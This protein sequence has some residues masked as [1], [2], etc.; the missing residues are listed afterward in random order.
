MFSQLPVRHSVHRGWVSLVPCP[1][2]EGV[3]LVQGPFQG[4]AMSRR[5]VVT[6]PPLQTWDTTGYDW[7]ARGIHP[8]GMLSCYR[9]IFVITRGNILTKK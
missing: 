2:W 8:T 4:V 7:K 6:Y 5:G 1:F 3:S 9:R